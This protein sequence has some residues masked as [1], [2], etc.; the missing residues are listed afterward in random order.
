MGMVTNM[1]NKTVILE[2]LNYS[3]RLISD[4]IGDLSK[5]DF[6][7]R[8]LISKAGYCIYSFQRLQNIIDENDDSGCQEWQGILNKLIERWTDD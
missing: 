5:S 1:I 7:K 8:D 2:E 3:L 4:M 6:D